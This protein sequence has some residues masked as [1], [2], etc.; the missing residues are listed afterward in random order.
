MNNPAKNQNNPANVNNSLTGFSVSKNYRYFFIFSGL[1]TVLAFIFILTG[2]LK[3]GIDFRGGTLWD[4]RFEENTDIGEI[5]DSLQAAGYSVST[6]LTNNQS[7]IIKTESLNQEQLDDL[8]KLITDKFGN[9]TENSFEAI[10]P[11]IGKELVSKAYWQIILVCLGIIFYISYSFRKVGSEMK[12]GSLSSWKM[13]AAAVIALIHD[14]I[15][16]VGVFAVLGRYKGVEIDSL[17]VTALLTILGFSVHD[18]IVVFDRIRESVKKYPYKSFA[19]VIDYSVASTLARSIN[20]SSTLI[21]V[22][23]A[24]ALF[25]GGTVYY[26]VLALLIGVTFGTYSSIF[27]ASPILYLWQKR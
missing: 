26:F 8:R 3:P 12:Q 14:L 7:V 22:L 18:T 11:S 6:Q 1:L 17:F 15:I 4:V 24:M 21:F 5:R 9:F 20:T 19:S 13:G 23:I 27:I 2:G 25:G 16:T 10:G